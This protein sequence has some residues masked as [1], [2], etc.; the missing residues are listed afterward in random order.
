VSGW[1]TRRGHYE[2]GYDPLEIAG[3]SRI[4][5]S[6]LKRDIYLRK[7]PEDPTLRQLAMEWAE[8]ETVSGRRRFW[9]G[10][11]S[12]FAIA[13]EFCGLY[14]FPEYPTCYVIAIG[15]QLIFILSTFANVLALNSRISKCTELTTTGSFETAI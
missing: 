10:T 1:L 15:V 13:L 3:L 8:Y 5:K 6:N 7:L 2:Y 14:N 9:Y 11:F 4:Q 12:L